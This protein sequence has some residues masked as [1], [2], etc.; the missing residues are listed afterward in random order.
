[1]QILMNLQHHAIKAEGWALNNWTMVSVV[2]L[3]SVRAVL[4]KPCKKLQDA[5][6]KIQ[7]VPGAGFERNGNPLGSQANVASARRP[8][9]GSQLSSDSQLAGAL[10]AGPGM[11]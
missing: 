3:F 10:P 4:E 2:S 9:M 7:K 6:S 1:M 11:G 8:I 5:R